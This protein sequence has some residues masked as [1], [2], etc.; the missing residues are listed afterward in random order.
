[1]ICPFNDVRQIEVDDIVASDNVRVN[2]ANKISPSSQH[3]S[4]VL[5]AVN[6]TAN[7]RCAL[8]QR[9]YIAHKNITLTL[10]LDDVSNLDDWVG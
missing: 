2:I 6:F 5:E 8:V 3:G 1:M 10:H 4:L 7:D 9:K